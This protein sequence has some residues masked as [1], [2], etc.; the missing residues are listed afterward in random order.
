MEVMKKIIAVGLIIVLGFG[1]ALAEPSGRGHTDVGSA[2][3]PTSI[4]SVSDFSY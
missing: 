3:I 4:S 1:I 2:S